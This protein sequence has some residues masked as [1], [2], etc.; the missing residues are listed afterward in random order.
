MN[1]QLSTSAPAIRAAVNNTKAAAPQSQFGQFVL[2]DMKGGSAAHEFRMTMVSAAIREALKGNSRALLEARDIATGKSKKAL[3]YFDGFAAIG[4][5]ARIAYAGKLSDPSNKAVLDQID[6]EASRLS[7]EFE[8]AFLA[9]FHVPAEPKAKPKKAKGKDAEQTEQTEQAEQAEQAT[10]TDQ[11]QSVELTVGEVI[12]A[13]ANAITAGAALPAEV[14]ML[15]EAL[16]LFDLR[17][18]VAAQEAAQGDAPFC[19]LIEKPAETVSAT[20]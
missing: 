10:S 6:A 4:I 20:A 8:L 19:L 7:T 11:L 3:S 16:A 17:A 13:A 1:S 14:Q 2:G 15:R 18:N 5:P 12:Q 9:R